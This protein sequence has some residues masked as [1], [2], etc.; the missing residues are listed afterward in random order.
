MFAQFFPLF[1]QYAG[2]SIINYFLDSFFYMIRNLHEYKWGI[3]N[4]LIKM[5]CVFSLLV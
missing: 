1:L 4:S 3:C 5:K 2:F